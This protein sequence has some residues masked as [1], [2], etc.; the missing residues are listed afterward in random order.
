[1]L[2]AF[3]I[4]LHMGFAFGGDDLARAMFS[5][6]DTRDL[7]AGNGSVIGVGIA[8]TPLRDGPHAL[9]ITVDQAVKFEEIRA[10]NASIFLTRFPLVTAVDYRFLLGGNWWFVCAGGVVYEYGINISGSGDLDD[11]DDDLDNALGFMGEGGVGYQER[12]FVA[13]FALRY[14]GISYT[15][16]GSEAEADADSFGFVVTGAYFF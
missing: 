5:N 4:S 1:A 7:K 6:G 16:P 9:G 13:D 8:L 11:V 14:T 12:S 2:G 15:A 10:S 3:G